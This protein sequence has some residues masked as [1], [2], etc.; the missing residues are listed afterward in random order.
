MVLSSQ[1]PELLHLN[2]NIS[3]AYML[4]K[5]DVK[6]SVVSYLNFT[7]TQRLVERVLPSVGI[8]GPEISDR[9][10]I[11]L[12]LTNEYEVTVHTCIQIDLLTVFSCS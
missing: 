8:S 4:R 7:C 6:L 2:T 12:C 9:L 5:D 3:S 11:K 1:N 10:M